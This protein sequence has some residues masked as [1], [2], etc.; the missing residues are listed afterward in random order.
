MNTAEP[1]IIYTPAKTVRV[2]GDVAEQARRQ[3]RHYRLQL[4]PD[5]VLWEEAKRQVDGADIIR[6]CVDSLNKYGL[7]HRVHVYGYTS[8]SY[9]VY[10][11]ATRFGNEWHL[12][13]DR[14]LAQILGLDLLHAACRDAI[15]A[16]WPEYSHVP[17]SEQ[18]LDALADLA[19]H[20][21][22]DAHWNPERA[23]RY[24]VAMATSAVS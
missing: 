20:E 5:Q 2:V 22:L 24:T 1:Q 14:R 18:R 17:L 3:D 10:A 4:N 13:S 15:Q 21:V 6:L 12:V 9:V 11:A 19:R 23:A 8:G 16:I 7:T